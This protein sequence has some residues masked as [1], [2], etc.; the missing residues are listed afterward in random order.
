MLDVTASHAERR[1]R[2]APRPDPFRLRLVD[3]ER[4]GA[5][6]DRGVT[7]GPLRDL[8]A[9]DLGRDV[10]ALLTSG[11][12]F[13]ERPLHA[14]D[15]A[16]LCETRRQCEIARAGLVAAGVEAVIAGSGSVFATEGAVTGTSWSAPATTT[17]TVT[18]SA[19]A[20]TIKFANDSAY[21]PDLDKISLS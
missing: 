12:T 19:G 2:G 14:G 21:A 6:Q 13:D 15:V 3:R 11:A 1:L 7:I 5:R 8:V 17:V 4:F 9:A 18:L 20:N 16:V 10:R